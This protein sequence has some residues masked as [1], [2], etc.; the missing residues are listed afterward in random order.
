MCN[1]IWLTALSEFFDV[2]HKEWGMLFRTNPIILVLN[3]VAE[4]RNVENM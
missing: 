3:A 4:Q 1:P 2:S